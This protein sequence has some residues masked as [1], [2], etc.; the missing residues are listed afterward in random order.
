MGFFW[1]VELVTDKG[2][3]EPLTPFNA[4]G[5]AAAPMAA[6]T[7]AAKERGL[8]PFVAGNRLQIAP[9]LVTTEEDIRRGLEILDE[10]LEV[11]D[12]YTRN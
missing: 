6:V 12:G 10:V 7:K 11:A 5:A 4:T 9:P 1:A 3:R 2:T 8:W